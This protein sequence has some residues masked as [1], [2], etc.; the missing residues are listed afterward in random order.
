MLALKTRD[1]RPVFLPWA[2]AVYAESDGVIRHGSIVTRLS[3][4]DS[5]SSLTVE[6]T[7][8]SAYPK[9]MPWTNTTKKLY[10]W[11]PADVIR[12]IWDYLQSHPL[13]NLGMRLN[14]TKSTA[15]VG[16][17]TPEVKNAKGEVTTQAVD[18]P[19][20][21][22]NY[23]T[24]DLGAL[25]DELAEAGALDS[26]SATNTAARGRNLGD[27]DIGFGKAGKRQGSRG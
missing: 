14:G 26:S 23:A 21:L 7:G 18:E 17:K 5:G 13:G 24:T 22:A 15:K 25:I 4:G 20:L 19:I 9:G 10:Q 6:S 11:D 8:F 12:L 3:T 27:S 16:V 2:T 1:G